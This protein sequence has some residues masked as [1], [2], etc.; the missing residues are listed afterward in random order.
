M[1]IRT[2][3]APGSVS[4]RRGSSAAPATSTRRFRWTASV[5]TPRCRVTATPPGRPMSDGRQLSDQYRRRFLAGVG[6]AAGA[7]AL[8]PGAYLV[9]L[10][11]AKPDDEAV[12]GAVRWGMLIDTDK[13]AEDCTAC[14]DAC[15]EE[16]GLAGSGRPQI[17]AQWIRKVELTDRS[18]GRKTSLPMPCLHC[19]HPPCVDEIGRAHV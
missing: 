6:I 15:N 12:T 2:T 8:V 13:C 11:V 18:T 16:H 4:T 7:S 5:A 10:A 19:A 9:Q 14:V 17:D 1:P 3:A